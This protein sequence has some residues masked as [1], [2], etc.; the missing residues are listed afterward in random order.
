MNLEKNMVFTENHR[1]IDRVT[2]GFAENLAILLLFNS[3]KVV[4]CSH[5]SHNKKMAIVRFSGIPTLFLGMW[6]DQIMRK[7]DENR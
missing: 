7:T 2:P 3:D 5:P 1:G 6:E 4:E